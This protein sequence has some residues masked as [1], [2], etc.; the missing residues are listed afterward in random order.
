M[1][2]GGRG[3]K[4]GKSGEAGREMMLVVVVGGEVCW[5]AGYRFQF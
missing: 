2:K 3:G 1:G 5:L 4:E